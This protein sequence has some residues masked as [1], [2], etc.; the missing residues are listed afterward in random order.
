VH[1]GFWQGYLR[2][3][4]NLEDSGTDAKIILKWI[5]EKWNGWHGPMSWLRIGTGGELL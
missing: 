2:E 5:F 4:D 3:G 1:T